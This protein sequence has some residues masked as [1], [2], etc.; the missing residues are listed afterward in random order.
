VR[1]LLVATLLTAV[2]PVLAGERTS[3]VRWPH[4][5]RAA[6][7]LTYDDALETQLRNARPALDKRQLRA[8]FFLTGESDS[9]RDQRAE[10]I[11]LGRSGH[12]LASHTMH[13]PCPRFHDWVKPGFALEDYTLDRMSEELDLSIGQIHALTSRKGP[14]TFAY[15][16]GDTLVGEGTASASYVPLVERKYL[17]A[18]GTETRVAIPGTFS[19]AEVPTAD[20]TDRSGPTLIDWVKKAEAQGGWVVFIFHGIGGQHIST[21]LE[22]HEALLD[23]L[24]KNKK[25]VWTAPFGEVAAFLKR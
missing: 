19:F 12:E 22:A 7:S 1:K 14:V 16:C 25:A 8:T 10:W 24:A 6:V 13:H 11:A 21:E 9:L 17:A 3:G 15:P 20:D 4:K 5:A 2:A 23:H 18:R